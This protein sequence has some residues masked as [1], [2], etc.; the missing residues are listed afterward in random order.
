M[1]TDEITTEPATEELTS[2]DEVPYSSHPYVQTHPYRLAVMGVLFGMTPAPVDRC[3]VLE[4]GCAGGRQPKSHGRGSA[5]EQLRW[6]RSV[7]RADRRRPADRRCAGLEK[8]RAKAPVDYGRER[9][10]GRIRLHHLSLRSSCGVPE[11]VRQKIL[12]ICAH[13]LTPQGIAYISYNTYPG[14]H[15]RGT[16]RDMMLYHSRKWEKP[17]E[18][19]GHAG[20][21]RLSGQIGPQSSGAHASLLRK[22]MELMKAQADYYILHE[23]LEAVNVP[24]YFHE[25]A[26]AAKASGLQFLAEAELGDVDEGCRRTSATLCGNCPKTLWDCEQYVDFIRNRT[27]LCMLLCRG[28]VTLD[29]ALRPSVFNRFTWLRRPCRKEQSRQKTNPKPSS[30]CPAER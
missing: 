2:Y 27:F 22:E 24:M 10:D 8:H 12:D 1:A 4:L 7:E 30:S 3:R 18:R 29:C 11:P 13:Q 16:V 20:V 15:M 9:C 6:H 14:W 19:V 5:R 21:A 25:F 28:D 26:S 23:H 17:Q